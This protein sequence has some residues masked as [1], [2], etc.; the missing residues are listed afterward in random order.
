MKNCQTLPRKLWPESLS[1]S[2]IS[3]LWA[4]LIF[5]VFP[6][7]MFAAIE[8]D[9]RPQD[10]VHQFDDTQFEGDLPPEG[11][12]SLFDFVVQ[13]NGGVPFPFEKLASAVADLNKGSAPPVTLLI[14]GGRSLVRSAS[15]FSQPR[16]LLAAGSPPK[17]DS[18]RLGFLLKNRLFIGYVEES[19]QL[20]VISYNEGAGRFEFQLVEDYDERQQP[21][22]IYARRNLCLTCHQNGATIFPVRPWSETNANPS[23]AERLVKAQGTRSHYHGV[24]LRHSLKAPESYDALTENAN[25]LLVAQRIWLTGCGGDQPESREC[26]RKLLLLSLKFLWEPSLF[27]L[28]ETKEY[29]P[30]QSLLKMLW[31]KESIALPNPDLTDRNPFKSA[32]LGGLISGDNELERDNFS[33]EED[34][35]TRRTAKRILHWDSDDGIFGISLFFTHEDIRLIK[36][37]SKINFARVIEV[38]Q[39]PDMQKHFTAHPIKRGAIMEALLQGL[40]VKSPPESCCEESEGLPAPL[41]TDVR[42]LEIAEGSPM[43]LF[44]NYC[45]A[46]HRGN[47]S[48][49]LD[50]MRGETERDVWKQ[51]AQVKTI[52]NVLDWEKYS[53]TKNEDQLMPPVGSYQYQ[54]LRRVRDGGRDPVAKMQAAALKTSTWMPS[55]EGNTTLLPRLSAFIALSVAMVA[56]IMLV[57]TSARRFAY[58]ER[59]AR[60]SRKSLVAKLGSTNQKPEN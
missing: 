53:G 47:P 54:L 29:P 44:K 2:N 50:F 4:A 43:K 8:L 16:T 26:R 15:T 6:N 7:N 9:R 42:R 24:P 10:A 52:A 30:F 33:H 5:F 55:G 59:L 27:D 28:S 48:Q 21:E 60:R 13:K 23:I 12:R 32:I 31:P 38:V 51:M 14:P 19:R 37:A 3:F 36:S 34:P 11:T 58:N 49:R 25:N 57:I 45:F 46:C 22:I 17:Q 35:L 20:E 39:S 56:S 18:K 40:G 41:Q 1:A